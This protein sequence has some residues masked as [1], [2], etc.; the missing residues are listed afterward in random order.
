MGGS[1]IFEKALDALS[2]SKIG[3]VVDRVSRHLFYIRSIGAPY[4]LLA[5]SY[6]YMK[7]SLF[8]NEGSMGFDYDGLGYPIADVARPYDNLYITP[9]FKKDTV[10]NSSS[11]YLEY[12]DKTV[13]SD[14]GSIRFL[15]EVNG[16]AENPETNYGLGYGVQNYDYASAFEDDMYD[17]G[18]VNPNGGYHDTRT[19]I[20][21][22]YY[23]S[24]TL[25]KANEKYKKSGNYMP[26]S[27]DDPTMLIDEANAITQGAYSM[28]GLDGKFGMKDGG[29]HQTVGRAMT[30]DEI[31]G[32]IIPWSTTDHFYDSY[33]TN[34]NGV[35]NVKYVKNMLG[36][37][38]DDKSIAQKFMDVTQGTDNGYIYGGFGNFYSYSYSQGLWNAT[39]KKVRNFISRAM[40]GLDMMSPDYNGVSL[41]NYEQ[42]T[43]T[44]PSNKKYFVG[45]G[46]R[47]TNYIDKI[48]ACDVKYRTETIEVNGNSTQV[49]IRVQLMDAGN[50][51]LWSTRALYTYAE[52]EGNRVGS[53]LTQ[54]TTV[55]T[56]NLGTEFGRVAAYDQSVT[57]KK[58][59]IINYTNERFRKGKLDTLIGRFHTDEFE[60]KAAARGNQDFTST[61]ISKYGMSRG[62]NLLKANHSSSKT[63]GY[64]DPYCRVW[65]FHHQYSNVSDLIRPFESQKEIEESSLIGKTRA[66][67]K[68]LSEYGAKT[69]IGLVRYAP[70][71]KDNI[72][73]CMFSI[74][75]LAWK[76]TDLENKGPNGGRIMWFPPYDLSFSENVNV[77]WQST[78]FIGRGEPI[79]T[80]TD[81]ERGGN[82]SFTLLI[83]HPQVANGF[84][85]A[86]RGVAGG[87]GIGDVD[88]TES[89]EQTL[90]RFF[91]GCEVLKGKVNDKEDRNTPKPKPI[92][93][94]DA[95]LASKE[96]KE[97][98][99]FAFF[100][101]NYS[102]VD[103]WAKME[104]NP[105]MYLLNGVSAQKERSQGGKEYNQGIGSDTKYTSDSEGKKRFGGY[106][107]RTNNG[108][109][110]GNSGTPIYEDDMQHITIPMHRKSKNGD[111]RDWYYRVDEWL[112]DEVLH[113]PQGKTD[114]TLNY[115]DSTSFQL[116]GNGYKKLVDYHTYAKNYKDG[117]FFSLADVYVALG[118]DEAEE[119]LDGLFDATRVDTLRT[120]LIDDGFVPVEVES[121]GF[122][123][124]HG[125]VKNNER[126]ASNRAST[127][128]SWLRMSS[129][130][131]KAKFLT[132]TSTYTK[133]LTHQ[134][135]NRIDAKAYRCV[136]CTISLERET[137]ADPQGIDNMQHFDNVTARGFKVVNDLVKNISDIIDEN[138]L[139]NATD[140]QKVSTRN[141]I[142]INKRNAEA[143]AL[144][145][146]KE[147]EFQPT[148]K[149]AYAD[150]EFDYFNDLKRNDPF[151]HSKIVEKLKYFDPAFHSVTPEGFNARLTFLQQCTRQG[152]TTSASDNLSY[153]NMAPANNVAF[154]A[155]PV[156]VLRVGDFYNT[157]IIIDSLN[158]RY[159]N[160]GVQW[161]MNDEGIGVS[162]MYAKVDITFKFVGGSDLTGPIRK[163]QNAVSFNYY[164]NT[165]VYENRVVTTSDAEQKAIDD[166]D[167]KVEEENNGTE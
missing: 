55:T 45:N 57:E 114:N 143:E 67:Q 141:N 3:D 91:A 50:D 113:T 156:C 78:R 115:K 109:T 120:I 14:G 164:A 39:S 16:I 27:Y 142:E 66:N 96:Y 107:V 76:N 97:I 123:S 155:P 40:L 121:V 22:N 41:E 64:S 10:K 25:F 62:R 134:D 80:Y 167:A 32:D 102:G 162:P 1:Q 103:D 94:K 33:N 23:L 166:K 148:P 13:F 112:S 131:S 135:V 79:Y 146:N 92:R 110:L 88:D 44:G 8:W 81:T 147:G 129:L 144:E 31:L 15:G 9:W 77:N 29:Y 63:N 117:E 140:L 47:G 60:S 74:E 53:P 70:T 58:P 2:K 98:T 127:I 118:G 116:N 93:T 165:S 48:T 69:D 132:E 12:L 125:Y 82:L 35:G 71:S 149:V 34:P 28:F 72:K 18:N 95:D 133:K 43:Y 111:Y 46:T 154:G 36:V 73:R 11:D 7:S 151:L 145:K 137:V 158:I 100:P 139:Q 99:F 119:V 106:E 128:N 105:L 24:R 42:G 122:A 163:L 61:A 104:V 52:A 65:T 136:R 161:D 85:S 68:L 160:N 49:P 20:I 150:N 59:D 83:D 84:T 153:A 101:N 130:F 124:S 51:N 4:S 21:N 5:K 26:P 6:P 126:L 152:S 87:D 138:Q 86:S 19:G 38:D 30:N 157:R 37:A 108:I 90:L 56:Y 75:N 89:N 17:N 54:G 159:D